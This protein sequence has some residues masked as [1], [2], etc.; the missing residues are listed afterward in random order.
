MEAR[1][2]IARN[3]GWYELHVLE[4]TFLG[5]IWVP[6]EADE[7]SRTRLTYEEAVQGFKNYQG[8]LPVKIVF[9]EPKTVRISTV[10][11]EEKEV[12]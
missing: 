2:V 6:V 4:K 12:R 10:V 7:S 11:E 1:E 3:E 5:I 8:K 9:M